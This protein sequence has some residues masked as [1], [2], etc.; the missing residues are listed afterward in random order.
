MRNALIPAVL[1]LGLAAAGCDQTVGADAGLQQR[2]DEQAGRIAALEKTDREL[3]EQVQQ[4]EWQLA[5]VGPKIEGLAETSKQSKA[6]LSRAVREAIDAEM[7]ARQ[8]RAEEERARRREEAQQRMAQLREE[9]MNKMAEALGLTD[10]QKKQVAA[11]SDQMREARREAFTQM[12]QQGGFDR[13][14]MAEL[15]ANMIAKTE[16][17]MKK[18]LTAE[19][20]A[21]Y[22][23]L[24]EEERVPGWRMRGRQ[25]R[26]ARQAPGGRQDR[27]ARARPDDKLPK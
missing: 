1:L 21:K 14:K 15:Q 7:A 23:A 4:L 20:F 17:G 18:I 8:A 19:Q 5:V 24:P 16:Q 25:D 26:G 9:Q 13:E 2:L 12:R 3:R 6:D 10:E 11:H 22:Q 27:G